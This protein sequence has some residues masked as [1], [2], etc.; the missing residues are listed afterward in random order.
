MLTSCYSPE[1]LF[2]F[3]A[4]FVGTAS[5]GPSTLA[6]MAVAVRSGRVRALT[7][8]AGVLSGSLFWSVS[9]AF[10]LSSLMQTCDWLLIALKT[11]GGCYLLWLACTAARSALGENARMAVRTIPVETPGAA[12]A[13]GIV[14]Q[15]TNPNAIFVW[16]SIVALALPIDLRSV[17]PVLVVT[18]FGL[19]AATVY[20]AY[21][22]AF[23]TEIA[24]RVYRAS[25]RWLQCAL[26]AVFA[27]AGVRLLLLEAIA[28]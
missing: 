13:K 1:L 23:S 6:I 17:G 18:G 7:L 4:C 8:A 12:Y 11:L 3:A 26:C 9:A 15:L 22:L 2:A 10:G 16:I 27:Y 25:H 19:I 21:A 14:M 20:S 5:P 28:Q 24:R